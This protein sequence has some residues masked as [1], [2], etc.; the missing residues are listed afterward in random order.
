MPDVDVRPAPHPYR[1]VREGKVLLE[2]SDALELHVRHGEHV[3][4]VVVYFSPAATEALDLRPSTT[5]APCPF[6]GLASYLHLG[7][8][9]DAAWTYP[10]PLP[11]VEK[12][13][14]HRAFDPGKGFVVEAVDG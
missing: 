10:E 6:K 3:V 2:T 13:A 8:V 14:N 7:D 11:I 4:P 1:L 5:T 12:I 9:E